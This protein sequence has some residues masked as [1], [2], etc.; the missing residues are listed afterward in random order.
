MAC[1][2]VPLAGRGEAAWGLGQARSAGG[3]QVSSISSSEG[4]QW[5]AQGG[6][7]GSLVRSLAWPLLLG[8]TCRS[9]SAEWPDLSGLSSRF[10]FQHPPGDPPSTGSPVCARGLSRALWAWASLPLKAE[11][12]RRA[13]PRGTALFP[14]V[15]VTFGGWVLAASAP[16][17]LNAAARC[18]LLPLGSSVPSCVVRGAHVPP[19]H[20]DAPMGRP[21][22]AGIS[23]PGPSRS[24]AAQ[25]CSCPRGDGADFCWVVTSL[26]LSAFAWRGM[27]C[28]FASQLHSGASTWAPDVLP[29][30]VAT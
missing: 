24:P 1:A 13:A 17:H 23:G 15:A 20:G 9:L 2:L 19:G 4:P 29:R 8:Q 3:A 10:C 25:P 12:C 14:D 27:G 7:P 18:L 5:P 6:A 28:T 30:L 21:T 22:A 16:S 11:R 26:D